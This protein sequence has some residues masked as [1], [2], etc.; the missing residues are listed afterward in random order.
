M[1]SKKSSIQTTKTF[2]KKLSK[3]KSDY[4]KVFIEIAPFVPRP[5]IKTPTTEGEWQTSTKLSLY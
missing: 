5:D 1:G 3:A 4:E 2:D